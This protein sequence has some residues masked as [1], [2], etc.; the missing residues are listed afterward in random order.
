MF[1]SIVLLLCLC[2]FTSNAL[3]AQQTPEQCGYTSAHERLL[4][5]SP[6]YRQAVLENEARIQKAI[7][8]GVQYEKATYNLP[9]V[10][11]II[12]K[13]EA[14]G[15]GTNITD[16]QV[17]SAIDALNRD[18]ANSEPTQSWGNP[19]GV[20]TDIQFCLAQRDPSG[21]PSTGINRVNGSSVA[22]YVSQG[23]VDGAGGNELQVKAL[24][25]WDNQKY[26]NIWCVTEINNQGSDNLGSYSGGT[27]GY[28]YF[29]GAG[30]GQDGIVIIYCAVGADP[31]GT[32]GYKLWAGSNNSDAMTHEI[33]H[34][35]SL[36]HT[37]A[38]GSCT[39]TNCNTQGD[40]VCDTPPTDQPGSCTNP[41]CTGRQ[42]DNWMD[43]T[44]SACTNRF[45]NGQKTRMIAACNAGRKNV[46]LSNG[47]VPVYARDVSVEAVVSPFSVTCSKSLTPEI[48]VKN[49]GSSTITSIQA[50]YS[51]D[52]G[53]AVSKTFAVNLVSGASTN[54]LFDPTNTVYGTHTFVATIL[55]VNGTTDQ[56]A[57][58][59]SKSQSF[60][61]ILGATVTINVKNY[62]TD[63]TNQDYFE[64]LQKNGT[65]VKKV[66]LN[67]AVGNYTE[68]LCLEPICYDFVLYDSRYIPSGYIDPGTSQPGKVPSFTVK[69]Y[70]GT[71]IASG[72]TGAPT[73]VSF[74]LPYS[75][76][77]QFCPKENPPCSINTTASSNSPVCEG[78]TINLTTPSKA[79]YTYKWTGP[80]SYL[81]TTAAPSIANAT[82]SMS[83]TYRVVV[84]S[85]GCPDTIDVVVTVNAKP[86]AVVTPMTSSSCGAV[87]FTLSGGTS[88]NWSRTGGMSGMPN[89]GTST[90]TISGTLINT[91][92]FDEIETFTVVAKSAAGCSSDPVMPSITIKPTPVLTLSP[93]TQKICSGAPL[94]ISFASNLSGTS[95]SWTRVNAAVSGYAM[96]GSG[97]GVS[98]TPVVTGLANV[99]D[100]IKVDGTLNGC[101]AQAKADYTV[102][103]L[104]GL[105]VSAFA[106]TVCSG[107]SFSIT[108]NPTISGSSVSWSRAN[109]GLSGLATSGTSTISGS[110]ANSSGSHQ[111][112]SFTVTADNQGCKKDSILHI[113]VVRPA[114]SL[115]ITVNSGIRQGDSIV[116]KAAAS[117]TVSWTG[118]AGFSATGDSVG[119][120]NVDFPNE[121]Y[122]YASVQNGPCV[123]KDSVYVSVSA[124]NCNLSV[125]I[126][127]A[128]STCQGS[129]KVLKAKPLNHSGSQTYSWS[130]PNSFGSTID[131]VILG[132]N[133]NQSG[134]YTVTVKDGFCTATAQHTITISAGP[135]VSLTT[136]STSN[137]EGDS[138][139][140]T[141]SGASTYVWEDGSTAN[142]RTI[143][144]TADANVS[145][146]GT[147]AGCS[148]TQT[149]LVTYVAKPVMVLSSNSPVQE[150]D[151]AFFSTSSTSGFTYSWSGPNGYT[152]SGTTQYISSIT[153]NKNGFYF[154]TGTHLSGCY[155][156]D[157]VF[158]NVVPA[159]CVTSIV[160]NTSVCEK[161]Q[162]QLTANV[163]STQVYTYTWTGPSYNTTGKTMTINPAAV[164]NSGN[165]KVVVSNAFCKDSAQ[166]PVNVLARPKA[167][168]LVATSG[169]NLSSYSYCQGSGPA[170]LIVQGLAAGETYTVNYGV[171]EQPAKTFAPVNLSS[172]SNSFTF[173]D[174]AGTYTVYL[175]SVVPQNAAIPCPFDGDTVSIT[176]KQRP[177]LALNVGAV[178][179]ICLGDSL[180]LFA[181]S[182][183]SGAVTFDFVEMNGLDPVIYKP[184]GTGSF[185]FYAK[186]V[187]AGTHS[188]AVRNLRDVAA[189]G[190]SAQISTVIVMNV[191]ANPT[192]TAAGPVAACE[193][194][195]FVLPVTVGGANNV[196]VYYKIDNTPAS[197]TFT[198]P[199]G[200]ITGT[201]SAGN[202]TVKLDSVLNT[203]A[204][205]KS[206]LNQTIAVTINAAPT[207]VLTYDPVKACVGDPVK[208]KIV[209][210]GTGN[211]FT[212]FYRNEA[213][214]LNFPNPATDSIII[215]RTAVAGM[216]YTLDS[217]R[218][219]STPNCTTVLN[220]NYP[221]V[222]NALPTASFSGPG[223]ICPDSTANLLVQMTGAAPFTI[224]YNSNL[225]PSVLNVS[226]NPANATI[227]VKPTADANYMFRKIRDNNGCEINGNPI[228]SVTV[229]IKTIPTVT[230]D[231]LLADSCAPYTARFVA[232]GSE[233]L[234][235]VLW[236]LT[237]GTTFSGSGPID[238]VLSSPGTY[239]ATVKAVGTSGCPAQVSESN[240]FTVYP[241]VDAAFNLVN[242]G[243]LDFLNNR[244]HV[245][246]L[247]QGATMYEWF[248]NDV[249]YSEVANPEL[250]FSEGDV[251]TYD[252]KLLVS[253]GSGVC[254]DSAFQQVFL[255]FVDQLHVPNT[256]TPDDDSYNQEF[257]PVFNSDKFSSYRF[258]IYDRWGNTVF[259]TTD[260]NLGWNGNLQNVLAPV[261]T[262]IWKLD[263]VHDFDQ[264][265]RSENGVVH[266]MR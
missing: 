73:T 260:P 107:Q 238:M 196:R 177:T 30:N 137:C 91:T 49:I 56:N 135:P 209:M 198:A 141:A 250:I 20:N 255:P 83:G 47:C 87:S 65:L 214:Q 236:T 136:S 22:N 226:G 90:S 150:G 100:T 191:I 105:T 37:F 142:P 127:G 33:G 52:G 222:V 179:S 251:Q 225:N 169:G 26:I 258:A 94:S 27:I 108:L 117:G 156:K 109:A 145:V 35:F 189:G 245:T 38:G 124:A 143:H 168:L 144:P 229:Q 246:N 138:T 213:G 59:N 160:G 118:P 44:G 115:A 80:N 71:T 187:V 249:A 129:T 34:Y 58:N 254:V 2:I 151:T 97:T 234:S 240:M 188:Y 19:A 96:S 126:T 139:V 252:V 112:E 54:L 199:G 200:N 1:R 171:I 208:V 146:T 263:Y 8:S 43:Y 131:S 104:S 194:T 60:K 119:V 184:S 128:T 106:D 155:F 120:N 205:C 66:M 36:D 17:I 197:Q 14:I 132:S 32:K 206:G 210:T 212:L 21:N 111:N 92:T 244:S 121:G 186:P 39:E 215:N 224:Q 181:T 114:Q 149:T 235:S 248:I 6:A 256:F 264:V 125:S 46:T 140:L 190:C 148:T 77:V 130:G 12:H 98:E 93:T 25:N 79:S 82:P 237:N 51:I 173:D 29:P 257:K 231:Q 147:T 75:D 16:A 220:Q 182:G 159:T 158:V 45:T 134:Q 110:L 170:N 164:T 69:D 28:A 5:S 55:Q 85:A 242:D 165:Y 193:N 195:P 157:S 261:A 243:N 18:F 9:V 216:T 113:L 88:Y 153:Q 74:V 180:R 265:K 207:A 68:V 99:S 13:G 154:V 4:E 15:T 50:E 86:V 61:V 123:I 167:S 228:S 219:L 64:I 247:S 152:A 204:G 178:P 72:Y 230:I 174:V 233:V 262:Y 84:D 23:I 76:T 53:V 163:A 218:S 122:Y 161:D 78:G 57:S 31:G 24:S 192:A 211:Q 176:I 101:T 162:L 67:D 241:Q 7:A 266:L 259:E 253:N 41:I 103:P 185:T 48:T 201:L 221:I 239:G 102:V 203:T 133:T 3:K 40:R 63:Y 81:N 232:N 175:K 89:S 217:V 202:H 10:V 11:H 166:V 42:V 223:S 183:G 116:L 227:K 95:F 70:T 172:A 62:E